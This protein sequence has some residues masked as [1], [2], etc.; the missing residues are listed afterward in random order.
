MERPLPPLPGD[1]ESI[2]ELEETT[3]EN[4]AYLSTQQ[5][6][7]FKLDAVES[8]D[9][10]KWTYLTPLRALVTSHTLPMTARVG[11]TFPD[12]ITEEGDL[13][14]L[15]F[16]VKR[17]RVLA[18][19]SDGTDVVLPIHASQLYDILPKGKLMYTNWIF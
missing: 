19:Y 17:K 5:N 7:C 4:Y 1:V 14:V 16:I 9:E 11:C 3:D 15:H 8:D 13:L 12:E 18:M 2:D 10:E 6:I